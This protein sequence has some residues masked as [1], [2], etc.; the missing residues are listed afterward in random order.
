MLVFLEEVLARLELPVLVQTLFW[1]PVELE[2]QRQVQ[3]QTAV[4]LFCD[5]MKLPEDWKLQSLENFVS[6]A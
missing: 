4:V 3:V 1:K 2:A 6:F 5:E